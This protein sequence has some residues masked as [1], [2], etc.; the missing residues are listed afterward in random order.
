MAVLVNRFCEMVFL[1]DLINKKCQSQFE[2]KA[3]G[4]VACLRCLFFKILRKR[5]FLVVLPFA[6]AISPPR[7]HLRR[8]S[9]LLALLLDLS[10]TLLALVQFFDKLTQ[11]LDR[12]SQR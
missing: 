8:G 1:I 10:T 4:N 9:K 6:R 7:C 5:F 12:A 3:V 2:I 11:S